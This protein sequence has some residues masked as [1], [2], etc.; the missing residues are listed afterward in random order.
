MTTDRKIVM[1]R[2]AGNSPEGGKYLEMLWNQ[3]LLSG[4][5]VFS[6][7]YVVIARKTSLSR[8]LQD[9]AIRK[10]RTKVWFHCQAFSLFGHPGL[11]FSLDIPS[12]KTELAATLEAVW[13][14]K[15]NV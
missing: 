7:S 2:L 6:M 4:S 11:S 9:L 10:L 13:E 12:L 1:T 14:G 8:K 3:H 5:S 15:G